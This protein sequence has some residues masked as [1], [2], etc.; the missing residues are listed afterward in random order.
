MCQ[1]SF[2]RLSSHFYSATN[3]TAEPINHSVEMNDEITDDTNW[4]QIN[5]NTL[6]YRPW[7]I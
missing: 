4:R 3:E 7:L 6:K 5:R 2:W 1:A